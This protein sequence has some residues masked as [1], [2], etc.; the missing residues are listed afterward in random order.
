MSRDMIPPLFKTI[1]SNKVTQTPFTS[2]YA[3]NKLCRVDNNNVV[4]ADAADANVMMI[5]NILRD[6]PGARTL[7]YSADRSFGDGE[8]IFLDSH[9]DI[10]DHV[11]AVG[12]S[13]FDIPEGTNK[14]VFPVSNVAVW[15]VRINTASIYYDATSRSLRHDEIFGFQEFVKTYQRNDL[16]PLVLKGDSSFKF[17]GEAAN[18]IKRV[19]KEQ[20]LSADLYLEVYRRSNHIDPVV[21]KHIYSHSDTHRFDFSSFLIVDDYVEIGLTRAGIEEYINAYSSIDF[22]IPVSELSPSKWRYERMTMVNTGNWSMSETASEVSRTW[23][24]SSV[25][26]YASYF[27]PFINFNKAE[28]S[29]G[30]KEHDMKTQGSGVTSSPASLGEYFFEA[31]ETVNLRINI[32]FGYKFS[33]RIQQGVITRRFIQLVA[34]K[35]DTFRVITAPNIDLQIP[36]ANG[37]RWFEFSNQETVQAGERLALCF[38]VQ[39]KGLQTDLN[40]ITLTINYEIVE[41]VLFN[42]AYTEK[43]NGSYNIDVIDPNLLCNRLLDNMTSTQGEYTSEILWKSNPYDVVMVA[44]ESLRGF[45]EAKV[46]TRFTDF[47]NWMQFLGYECQYRGYKLTWE[48]RDNFYDR[49]M[50]ATEQSGKEVRD[51]HINANIDHVF[52]TAEVGYEKQSY[53]NVNGRFEVMNGVCS[54]MASHK[55]AYDNK[56]VVREKADFKLVSPYRADCMGMEFLI[57]TQGNRSADS[58][59]DNDL[60]FLAAKKEGEMYREYRD[61]IIRSE[62]ADFP[63]SKLELF[64]APFHPYYIIKRNESV[65]GINT[66]QLRFTGAEGNGNVSIFGDSVNLLSN[67]EITKSLFTPFQLTFFV[68]SI[69]ELPSIDQLRG[70][71]RVRYRGQVY[72]GFIRSLAKIEYD[73]QNRLSQWIVDLI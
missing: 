63:G 33:S 11:R 1:I 20:G 67:I 19:A 12:G 30:S 56:D 54:Y 60:F 9:G 4:Y 49:T 55:G 31:K 8:I 13:I 66:R 37:V 18:I 21:R 7:R 34:I 3:A 58:D 69:Q 46:R 24:G 5:N 28:M 52:T 73:P 23:F 45:K 25:T 72:E 68:G 2:L 17:I 32:N 71:L 10:L 40:P 42:I 22:D 51:F 44:A 15:N 39:S 57:W 29:L 50:I 16:N 59:S 53:D 47:L 70:L 38:M 36:D 35:G 43:P 64:N 41:D 61:V 26:E 14:I 62:L 48:P 6:H 65:F 27:Y